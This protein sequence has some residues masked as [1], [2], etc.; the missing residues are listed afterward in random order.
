M[1]FKQIVALVRT[2]SLELVK[3]RLGLEGVKAATVSPVEG[4]GLHS[5]LSAASYFGALVSHSRLD[6][7]AD[8]STVARIVDAILEAGHTGEPGDG[9]VAVLPVE[10]AY[11]IRTR[12][13]LTAD[14]L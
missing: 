3:E 6:I 9:L 4:I 1:A 12:Q 14:S 13:P 7:Y 2:S 10:Q 11:Q 5:V 8:E